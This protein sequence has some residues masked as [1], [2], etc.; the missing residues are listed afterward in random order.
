MA[1]CAVRTMSVLHVDVN[2]T[3]INAH[4]GCLEGST[5]QALCN[6]SGSSQR[7]IQSANHAACPSRTGA[8]CRVSE[9]TP[10]VYVHGT[11]CSLVHCCQLATFTQLCLEKHGSYYSRRSEPST[12]THFRVSPR[13]SCTALPVSV[14]T[15]AADSREAVR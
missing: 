1:R 9:P 5:Y 7:P 8:S 3:D 13:F 11:P 6:A 14:R 15:Q 10:Q 2:K 12:V 4:P